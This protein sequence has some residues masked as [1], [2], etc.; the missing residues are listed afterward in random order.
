MRHGGNRRRR[1]HNL[2][3]RIRVPNFRPSKSTHVDRPN[4]N[5]ITHESTLGDVLQRKDRVHRRRS[6]QIGPSTGRDEANV[7]QHL[8]R[9]TLLNIKHV[10]RQINRGDPLVTAT[11]AG[12]NRNRGRR[13]DRIATECVH[14]AVLV[15]V[16]MVLVAA[17][18]W[19]GRR[20]RL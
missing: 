7:L 1:R 15:M 3:K 17:R 20:R 11:V 16:M 5:T 19:T 8:R 14:H 9:L 10:L 13:Q 2:T 12:R 4:L 6:V 18:R